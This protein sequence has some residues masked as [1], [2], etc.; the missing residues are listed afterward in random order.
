MVFVLCLYFEKYPFPLTGKNFTGEFDIQENLYLSGLIL[1]GSYYVLS[2]AALAPTYFRDYYKGSSSIAAFAFISLITFLP[3][4]MLVFFGYAN[5]CHFE[6]LLLN[7]AW[8]RRIVTSTR[9]ILIMSSVTGFF[10]GGFVTLVFFCS[11]LYLVMLLVAIC[12]AAAEYDAYSWYRR[13]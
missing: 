8:L 1:E 2:R 9:I 6:K 10:A 7:L 3:S 4:D 11:F 13:A 12:P 5:Y